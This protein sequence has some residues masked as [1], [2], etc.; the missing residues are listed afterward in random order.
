MGEWI[1]AHISLLI[2]KRGFCIHCFNEF[3]FFYIN[4]TGII[5]FIDSSREKEIL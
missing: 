1:L 5:A 3:L 2:E 4:L